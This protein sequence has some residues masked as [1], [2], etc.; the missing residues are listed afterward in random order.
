DRHEAY[1]WQPSMPPG[2]PR[3]PVP[4]LAPLAAIQS[5][6]WTAILSVARWIAPAAA[7]TKRDALTSPLCSQPTNRASL[8][9]SSASA[10]DRF[11]SRQHSQLPLPAAPDGKEAPQTRGLQV[12]RLQADVDQQKVVRGPMW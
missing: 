11:L 7:P 6:G 5:L 4:T 12:K 9:L 8:H 3:W 10:Y 1:C 2:F